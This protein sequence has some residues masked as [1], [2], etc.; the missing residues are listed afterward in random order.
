MKLIYDFLGEESFEHDFKDVSY[1]APTFDAQL[2]LKG[3]HTVHKEV[4][5]RP[6]QTILPPDLFERYAKLSF[7]RNLPNSRAFRIVVQQQNVQ[8][9]EETMPEPRHTAQTVGETSS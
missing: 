4:A 3:L 8:P 7:W 6:R 5:P 9:V 2:G 1:D